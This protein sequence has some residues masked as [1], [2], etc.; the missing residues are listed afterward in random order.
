V[1]SALSLIHGKAVRGARRPAKHWIIR[2]PKVSGA[3]GGLALSRAEAAR[4]EATR[5]EATRAEAAAVATVATSRAARRPAAASARGQAGGQVAAPSATT[6][7]GGAASAASDELVLH[8]LD[9]K[10]AS[11]VTARSKRRAR[12]WEPARRRRRIGRGRSGHHPFPEERHGGRRRC[13]RRDD[14]GNKAAGNHASQ[15]EESESIERNG[16]GPV[17]DAV[18]NEAMTNEA[19]SNRDKHHTP[20]TISERCTHK[21]TRN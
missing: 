16:Q 8:R 18:L 7:G 15:P 1:S 10:P 4:A 14:G 6:P 11:N 9:V 19:S 21:Q 3:A 20:L 5:A 13:C 17:A 12:G 2:R